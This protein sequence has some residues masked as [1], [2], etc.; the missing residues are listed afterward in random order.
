MSASV[1]GAFTLRALGALSRL[2]LPG[3]TDG[4]LL[5][6]FR[7]MS[8]S[9]N[10]PRDHHETWCRAVGVDPDRVATVRVQGG[11]LNGLCRLLGRVYASGSCATKVVG[12][13]LATWASHRLAAL[14]RGVVFIFIPHII[15]LDPNARRD[16][17]AAPP[18]EWSWERPSAKAALT[19]LV[20]GSL[21]AG[22]SQPALDFSAPA[23]DPQ[24]IDPQG[25]SSLLYRD[26]EEGVGGRARG[27]PR[28]PG[29][30][31]P[32]DGL[33]ALVEG[34]AQP[35]TD[36]RPYRV[37]PQARNRLAAIVGRHGVEA[38][39]SALTE[40]AVNYAIE[41]PIGWLDKT[42]AESPPPAE[43]P[44]IEAAVRGC[45]PDPERGP[46]RRLSDEERRA[47]AQLVERHGQDKVLEAMPKAG[48]CGLPVQRLDAVLSGR[49]GRSKPPPEDFPW[50]K[51]KAEE[52]RR[53]RAGLLTGS[54]RMTDEE[55][56]EW[57]RQDEERLRLLD[58]AFAR[59]EEQRRREAEE[60]RARAEAERARAEAERARQEALR[61][62]VL[63]KLQ[64]FMA[65]G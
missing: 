46:K 62:H 18:V 4:A 49:S 64:R 42:L 54:G 52:E 32:I 20:A 57:A 63:A 39:R 19:A 1:H 22:S 23:A 10:T 45:I 24:G 17:R 5:D 11:G 40:I 61:P 47:L 59:Q 26:Q 55:R 8:L 50:R 41:H 14:R 31:D 2:H 36:G 7:L 27:A 60:E 51:R 28:P 43:E 21:E 38:C 56:A 13:H 9:S 65:A 16:E 34:V 3:R 30:D 37:P 6:L 44:P 25:I 53:R 33:V 48:G 58:E 29:A 12:G 35:L 15:A